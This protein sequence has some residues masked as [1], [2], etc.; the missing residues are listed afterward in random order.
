MQSPSPDQPRRLALRIR[1][2]VQGVGF[3]PF[4]YNQA[5]ELRLQGWVRNESGEVRIEIEGGCA[6]LDCFMER[7][8]TRPP[9]QARIDDLVAED[10]PR[11]D[12]ADE[13]FRIDM[14]QV[15]APPRP[16]IPAELAIC[17]ACRAELADPRERRYQYPFT[18]CTNCGPRWSIIEEL[19]YDRPRTT[20]A[21][22]AMCDRC[23]AEYEN[24][25]DRRFHAQPIA[26]PACGPK[27]SLL[28]PRGERLAEGH[29]ALEQAIASLRQ[30]GIVA[31]KGIGGF[32]LLVDATDQST[33][34]RLR[35]RKRRPQRPFAVMMASLEDVRRHC[36]VSEHEARWLQSTEA[37][38][39]LLRRL[40]ASDFANSLANHPAIAEAVAPGNPYLGTML[41][42]TP[43][44]H[45][46]LEGVGRP[47]VCT[48]GNLAEEPMAIETAEAMQ[49]L[50]PI[51]D[52]ILTHDRPI[53][54]PVD[55]SVAQVGSR[56]LELLRRAR[57][58]APRPIE[59]GFELP[60][61][62]A[63]GG[64]LKNTVAL[65]LGSQVVVGSHVGDLE[66]VA[67]IGVFRRA[68]DD[69]LRFFQA[70]PAAIACDLHPDYASTRYA[71]ELAQRFGVP[72]VRV[73]H[74]HAHAA[75]CM[76]EHRLTGPVLGLCWDGTG[77]GDDGTVWGGEV[78]TCEKDAF[79]RFAHLRTFPLPGGDRAAR[80]PRRSALGLLYAL[81][82][83]LAA[84]QARQWFR[85]GELKTLLSAVFSS[86]NAPQTS[87]L[88]RLFDAVAALC[89]LRSVSSF[90]GEAAMAL[91]FAADPSETAAYPLPPTAPADGCGAAAPLVADWGPML[92]AILADLDRGEA[93]AVISA[94]F[95]NALAEFA[96]DAAQRAGIEQIVLGG[97]CF[98]N[99]LLA[100]RV[101]SS[102]TRGGF[103]VEWNRD[104]PPGDGS[105]A[106]GQLF[107][108]AQRLSRA[109]PRTLNP[110]P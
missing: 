37:P 61:I 94:R 38:I 89:G 57:G 21:G 75:A 26:C 46:I 88:G 101:V 45:L 100:E 5:R 68:V 16:T 12:D 78:L 54:R 86:V 90:E 77:Y 35:E 25:A 34:E 33:I 47:I 4:V 11:R 81:N 72:L 63:V 20:M 23:R 29:A 19:P 65:S 6:E 64:H 110:E 1:G 55:D 42:Y 73:Q 95:H 96:G 107:V 27:L 40:A 87:S 14:S 98:Q 2:I 43:L 3:R 67:S 76:A 66:S 9:P 51:A 109:E 41:P 106:I 74:H 93:P 56:G 10:I 62:L 13:G 69:L 102:L 39:L 80:E 99:T 59:L 103:R 49:R 31:L 17:A 79:H 105:I 60:T 7:L 22:F 44:H 50:G 18:N 85:E 108:A 91:Q 8:R 97:G 32:Q 70:K 58:F 83:A 82:P 53:V 92:D 24:P 15:G 28:T 48:S 52:L 36:A 84:Q 71:E 30:G 104:V